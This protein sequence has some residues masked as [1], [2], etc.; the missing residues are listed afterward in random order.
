MLI[1]GLGWVLPALWTRDASRSLTRDE[2]A[3]AAY[4][5][6]AAEL[7]QDFQDGVIDADQLA[8][9]EDDLAAELL[10]D[11]KN[12]ADSA[13]SQ[14]RP[15]LTAGVLGLAT[16]AFAGAVY[17]ELGEP[18]ALGISGKGTPRVAPAQAAGPQGAAPQGQSAMPSIEEMVGSLAK[19][20]ESEPEDGTGWMMLGRSYTVLGRLEEAESALQKA[21]QLL[22]DEPDALAAY[23]EVLGRRNNNDLR[24]K[25]TDLLE[26]RA[27]KA[28][29]PCKDTLADRYRGDATR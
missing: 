18:D 19:R 22:P 2:F 10:N 7:K 9:A 12:E 17:F 20:L 6:R 3:V 26:D 5:Q 24:G 4:E 8:S 15:M 11:Y 29:D 1:A 25:P 23:A 21:V 14:T 13:Q 16:A 28:A 27:T